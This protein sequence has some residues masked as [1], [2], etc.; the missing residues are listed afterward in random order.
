MQYS[1]I[2]VMINVVFHLHLHYFLFE[3]NYFLLLIILMMIYFSFFFMIHY[4]YFHVTEMMENFTSLIRSPPIILS[5]SQADP[6]INC[7]K[8]FKKIFSRNNFTTYAILM[9]N[10]P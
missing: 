10:H 4:A 1:I 6:Q 5:I 7:I 3:N 8:F 9:N 2:L